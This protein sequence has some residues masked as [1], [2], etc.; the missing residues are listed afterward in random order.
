MHI[1][2]K[3]NIFLDNTHCVITK[4][5]FMSVTGVPKIKAEFVWHKMWLGFF[6]EWL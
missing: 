5:T 2:L 4:K 1:F 6:I 3:A